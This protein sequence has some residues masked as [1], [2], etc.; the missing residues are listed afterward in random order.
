MPNDDVIEALGIWKAWAEFNLGEV[1]REW[2]PAS[3]WDFSREDTQRFVKCTNWNNLIEAL[4][5]AIA[6]LRAT[7]R[8]E[9]GRWRLLPSCLLRRALSIKQDQRCLPLQAGR[10]E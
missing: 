1:G 4:D 10:V 7:E 6:A 9:A 5:A 2:S 3:G 8:G